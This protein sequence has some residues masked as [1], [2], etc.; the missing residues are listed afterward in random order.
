[1]SQS[2]FPEDPLADVRKDTKLKVSAETQKKLENLQKSNVFNFVWQEF[3]KGKYTR[4]IDFPHQGY[5]RYEIKGDT[6]TCKEKHTSYNKP[7]IYKYARIVLLADSPLGLQVCIMY[8][9]ADGGYEYGF[10]DCCIE[11]GEVVKDAI[12]GEME[13]RDTN[14]GEPFCRLNDQTWVEKRKPVVQITQVF[15]FEQIPQLVSPDETIYWIPIDKIN[16][17]IRNPTFKYGCIILQC[18]QL[19]T[20]VEL[21]SKLNGQYSM[22][23]V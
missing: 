13:C 22:R 7:P 12:I 11:D 15:V 4:L 20:L 2:N 9:Y 8:G 18:Q 10:F 16:I 23:K 1:M 17:D 21:I 3:D 6:I 19:A 5:A 14:I